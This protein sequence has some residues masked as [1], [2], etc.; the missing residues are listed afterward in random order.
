MRLHNIMFY[1]KNVVGIIVF[2]YLFLT[3]MEF[4]MRCLSL[5]EEFNANRPFLVALVVTSHENIDNVLFSGRIS[6][7]K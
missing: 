5:M 1:A 2:Y 7:P 4:E 3:G 6:V